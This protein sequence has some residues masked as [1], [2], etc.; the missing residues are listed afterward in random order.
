MKKNQWT[1]MSRP[2]DL[3]EAVFMT[4]YSHLEH[5]H[6]H[7]LTRRSKKCSLQTTH[8]RAYLFKSQ[9]LYLSF[10]YFLLTETF[11]SK[12]RCFLFF[13]KLFVFICKC[14][15]SMC[16]CQNARFI[17]LNKTVLQALPVCQCLTFQLKLA[18]QFWWHKFSLFFS[19]LFL[20]ISSLSS[21]FPI[22]P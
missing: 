19:L 9:E 13:P 17:T 4:S 11:G 3:K 12:Q 18:Q 7:I 1:Y 16:L 14:M 8:C 10:S 22:P 2:I 21:L 15:M 20:V 6:A 5:F